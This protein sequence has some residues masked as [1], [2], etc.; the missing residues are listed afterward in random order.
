MADSLCLTCLLL[1]P[2]AFFAIARGCF[3]SFGRLQWLLRGLVALPLL[4][5]GIGHFARTALFASIVP[6]AFPH[7]VG[8]VWASGVFELA[9]AAGI[10]LPRASRL[11][12]L[13][14]TLL[15]IA[16]FPANIYA[17]HRVVGGLQMPGVPVRLAMQA[18]Y[19]V[20]ILLAGWGL[21]GRGGWTPWKLPA[22]NLP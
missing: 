8:L 19:I 21:P 16:V 15:M 20:W 22:A 5:S 4:V 3:R 17:A 2:I 7:P 13:C 10:L 14:L 6:P 12:S 9:G 18:V 11:A 1:L